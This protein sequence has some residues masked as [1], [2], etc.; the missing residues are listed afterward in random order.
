MEGRERIGKDDLVNC[1]FQAP[2][3]RRQLMERELR[4]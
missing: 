1:M 4:A 2:S 3:Y